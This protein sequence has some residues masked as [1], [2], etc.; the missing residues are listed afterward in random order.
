MGLITR[1]TAYAAVICAAVYLPPKL[2]VGLDHQ[3]Q[4]QLEQLGQLGRERHSVACDELSLFHQRLYRPSLTTMDTPTSI[5]SFTLAD[6]IAAV[7]HHR[8]QRSPRAKCFQPRR[9]EASGG[10]TFNVAGDQTLTLNPV[11]AGGS[12]SRADSAPRLSTGA[13]T[14]SGPTVVNGGFL[15]VSTLA[16]GGIRAPSANR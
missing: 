16:T 13:N 14:Y 15:Q 11:L 12:L 3:C 7:A 9:R 4:Q 2:L 5:T 1:Y 8:G 6:W 10:T